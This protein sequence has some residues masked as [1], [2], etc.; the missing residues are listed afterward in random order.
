MKQQ[1]VCLSLLLASLHLGCATDTELQGAQ[2]DAVTLAR[3]QSERHQTVET[4][5]QQLNDRVLKFGPSQE[6]TR[7]S[8]SRLV[9]TVDDVRIQLQRLQADIQETLRRAQ[10]SAGG[11]AD[12]QSAAKLSEFDARLGELEKQLR[13]LAP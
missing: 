3:Q 5:L 7:R 11:A 2:V 6:E 8:V 9:T 10:R 12:P 13:T 1:V 4:R